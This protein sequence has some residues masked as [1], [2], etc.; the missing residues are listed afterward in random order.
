MSVE[1]MIVDQADAGIRLD[2]WFKRRFPTITHGRLEKLLR[3]GQ[4]RVDGGRVKASLRLK[5]GQTVRVP[6]LGDLAKPP[7]PRPTRPMTEHE[8]ADL[9]KRVLYRDDHVLLIDK[10]TGLAV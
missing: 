9:R 10:P 8:A 2:R 3:T 7:P 6:P 5:V 1:N 4:V